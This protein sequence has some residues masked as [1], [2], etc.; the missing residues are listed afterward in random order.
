MFQIDGLN[1]D[2]IILNG[3]ELY[4]RAVA[5]V[6]EQGYTRMNTFQDNNPSGE[7]KTKGFITDFGDIVF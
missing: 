7:K 5:E 2:A 6:Q 1:G 4:K 3:L